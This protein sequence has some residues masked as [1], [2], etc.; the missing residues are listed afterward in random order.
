MAGTSNGKAASSGT[1][2]DNERNA[3]FMETASG[4]RVASVQIAGLV[5]RRIVCRVGEGEELGR[6]ERYGLIRFGS[7]TD[8]LLPPTAE[9]RT[10]RGEPVRGGKSVIAQLPWD[11]Q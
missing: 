10:R 4:D 7:R 6:G 2:T 5:A 3:L 11:E 1:S 9:L 8:V